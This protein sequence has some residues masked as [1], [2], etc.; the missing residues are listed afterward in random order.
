MI[1]KLRTN[2][3]RPLIFHPVSSKENNFIIYF[4]MPHYAKSDAISE[5]D[6]KFKLKYLINKTLE[7]KSTKQ[8]VLQFK[9]SFT[10]RNK[11]FRFINT[12]TKTIPQ[13]NDCLFV[14]IKFKAMVHAFQYV[15]Y[16][17]QRKEWFV[18]VCGV[19]HYGSFKAVAV[20]H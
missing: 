18:C 14:Y 11:N 20:K 16:F 7:R 9:G 3:S 17:G 15:P 12:L 8:F 5:Q 4:L 13:I 10:L 2:M 6:K 19:L 1:Y